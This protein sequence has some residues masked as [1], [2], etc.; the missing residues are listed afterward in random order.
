M[1]EKVMGFPCWH[2]FPHGIRKCESKCSRCGIKEDISLGGWFQ[3]MIVPDYTTD[4]N[5]AFLAQAMVIEKVGISKYGLELA[6]VIGGSFAVSFD[7]FAR[8]A[9]AD[10][11]TRCL[12][13][14]KAEGME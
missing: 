1:S 7:C 4:L 14:I 10:A 12:A 13:V 6:N 2:N 9:T 8:F 11:L 3:P 5:A